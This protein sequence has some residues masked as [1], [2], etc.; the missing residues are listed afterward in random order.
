MEIIKYRLFNNYKMRAF[1]ILFVLVLISI[2]AYAETGFT[3]V[4]LVPLN[5]SANFYRSSDYQFFRLLYTVVSDK[6]LL[7]LDYRAY[8]YRNRVRNYTLPMSTNY[9]SFDY[10]NRTTIA[11]KSLNDEYVNFGRYSNLYNSK[12][13]I[14]IPFESSNSTHVK[15]WV[16]DP[17]YRVTSLQYN[18]SCALGMC[19]YFDGTSS[20]IN[21]TTHINYTGTFSVSAWIKPIGR[22][23]NGFGRIIEW[24]TSSGAASLQLYIIDM[25]NNHYNLSLYVDFSTRSL[26]YR[27]NAILINNS[28]T[29][30]YFNVSR[31]ASDIYINGTKLSD[32]DYALKQTQ[33]GI[34][35]ITPTTIPIIGN[36]QAK[37]RTFKGY[38]DEFYYF[39]SSNIGSDY[40]YALSQHKS[41]IANEYN[42]MFPTS[43]SSGSPRTVS[44]KLYSTDAAFTISWWEKLYKISGLTPG[45]VILGSNTTTSAIGRKVPDSNYVLFGNAFEECDSG[46]VPTYDMNWHNIVVSV[47]S[48]KC[49]WYRDGINIT[50]GSSDVLISGPFTFSNLGGSG[51]GYTAMKGFLDDLRFYNSTALTQKEVKMIMNNSI[52]LYNPTNGTYYVNVTFKKQ[53]GNETNNT[54]SIKANVY[55]S[56]IRITTYD[57]RSVRLSNVNANMTRSGVIVKVL[58]SGNYTELNISY[59][60]YKLGVWKAGYGN[61]SYSSVVVNTSSMNI[62]LSIPARFTTIVRDEKSN[63]WFDTSNVNISTIRIYSNGTNESNDFYDLKVVGDNLTILRTKIKNLRLETVHKNGEVISVYVDPSIVNVSSITLCDNNQTVLKY[64]QYIL[65]SSQKEVFIQNYYT[66]CYVAADYTRFAYQNSYILRFWTIDSSYTLSTINNGVPIV[67]SNIDGSIEQTINLD[68]LVFTAEQTPISIANDGLSFQRVASSNIIKIYYN[69]YKED[70]DNASISIYRTDTNSLLYTGGGFANNNEFIVYFDFSS[71]TGVT[72]DTIFKAVVTKTVNGKVSTKT[73]YFNILATNSFLTS[74]FAFV[75]ALLLAVFGLTF[76]AIKYTFSW[77]GIIVMIGSIAIASMGTSAW[78][79]TF[80]ITMDIIIMV[81]IGILMFVQNSETVA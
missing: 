3:N 29:H 55:Q 20:L 34:F 67:L 81:F 24:S 18:N 46:Q 10:D 28:W 14:Y 63:K 35:S 59:G 26:N 68:S 64:P 62:T 56:R 23:E 31:Y 49:T 77:F 79:L 7:P 58:G 78:Y 15:P 1:V 72:N 54:K 37:D 70:N 80:L 36:N 38:I 33:L 13:K 16:G 53:V 42:I 51:V 47:L 73:E 43:L 45:Y 50:S 12:T 11:D 48:G 41:R 9:Y 71:L 25:Q 19:S 6:I 52:Y 69:N 32:S 8:I 65:S 5:N 74:E 30:V 75:L 57:D 4:R 76:T 27:T 21:L 44:S 66:K 60:T 61:Y 2:G 39:N 22:G 17:G 40:V